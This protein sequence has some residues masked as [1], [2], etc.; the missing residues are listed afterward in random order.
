MTQNVLHGWQDR[1][2]NAMAAA[3]GL[4]V[5]QFATSFQDRHED[6]KP[7]HDHTGQPVEI[8]G[9][10]IEPSKAPE[11]F[12]EEALPYFK[13]RFDDGVELVV[14]EEELF[15]RNPALREVMTAV[16]SG[17]AVA[18][19]MGYVGPYHLADEGSDEEK[20]RFIREVLTFQV[21]WT[22]PNTNTPEEFRVDWTYPND[23]LPPAF[24]TDRL[25][26]A[27][28]AYPKEQTPGT[29]LVSLDGG[30]TYKPA[31][32]GVRVIYPNI[33]VDGEDERGELHINCTHEGIIKDVWVTREEHLDH[34]IG[35][36]S[37]G[38]G[39][40]I[41]RLVEANA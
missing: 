12:D 32:S 15:T 11:N 24:R 4:K 36:D 31:P 8:V 41:T 33:E 17:F 16:A 28:P 23:K 40:I 20:Q 2:A 5:E 19:E 14:G 30:V 18:R 25:A 35:T 10:F 34:N 7:Y 29:M 38:T 37:V 6:N 9:L 21:E 13:G 3:K 39:D 1:M 27:K 26:K 22:Y